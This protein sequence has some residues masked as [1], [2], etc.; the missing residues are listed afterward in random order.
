MSNRPEEPNDFEKPDFLTRI[1]ESPSEGYPGA[2]ET[3]PVFGEESAA[4]PIQQTGGESTD[5]V[6]IPTEGTTPLM[7][8]PEPESVPSGEIPEEKTSAAEEEEEP[9]GPTFWERLTAQL[10]TY[11][12][13]LLV[14]LLAITVAVVL[15]G[16]ELSAYHWDI[17]AKSFTGG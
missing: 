17:G 5:S 6:E 15:L 2:M 14:S 8:I 12:V 1:P 7:G 3:G 11:T 9:A 10:D 16:L 4:P 13:I